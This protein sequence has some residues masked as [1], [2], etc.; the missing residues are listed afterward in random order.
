MPLILDRSTVASIFTMEA[1]LDRA[2]ESFNALARGETAMPQRIALRVE[3]HSGT[4]LTMPCHVSS[5]GREVLSVKL[6]TVFERNSEQGLPTTL[7]TLVLHDPHT[8]ELLALMDAEHLTAMRTGAGAGLATQLLAQPQAQQVAIFGS[9]GQARAQLEAMCAVRPIRKAFVFSRSCDTAE[10]F[11]RAFTQIETVPCGDRSVIRECQIIC[12]A[13]N[14]ITPVVAFEEIAPGTHINSI[15]AFRPDM[16][17]LDDATVAASRVFVDRL[18]AAKNGAGELTQAA[19]AGAFSWEQCSELG[20]VL[21][22]I[23]PGRQSSEEVTLFKS[24]GVAVQ[25]AVAAGWIYS[26]A[27]ERGLG[28]NFSL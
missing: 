6:A 24:V 21:L 9:G 15:G 25:D 11:A 20:D 7:A 26:Q 1:A 8:G 3:E 5:N 16:R 18:E 12:T 10:V 27:V 13:T 2:R 22:G 4:H 17:E 14:S 28:Q 19:E 23:V